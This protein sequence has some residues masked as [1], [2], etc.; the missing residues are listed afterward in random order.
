MVGKG[1]LAASF[2]PIALISNATRVMATG[3]LWR[4]I[5]ERGRAQVQP[6][7][8]RI[9][10]DRLRRTLFALVLWYLGKVVGEVDLAPLPRLLDF[11]R[12]GTTAVR[13]CE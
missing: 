5:S 3:L 4:Y 1:G 6:R 2:I 10:H 13:A 8:R 11:E 7:H 12:L 9:C